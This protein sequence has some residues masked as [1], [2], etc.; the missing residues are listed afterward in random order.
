MF[1]KWFGT[2]AI[3]RNRTRI[4]FERTGEYVPGYATGLYTINPDGSDVRH[5]RPSGQSPRWSPDGHWI[6]FSEGTP[7]NGG[8]QSVFLMKPDGSN[9]RQL[10]YHKDVD[11]T[12]PFW[13]PDSK[14]LAYSLW[15]SNEK[16]YQLCVV[17]IS[18]RRWKHLLYVED[19]IYPVWSPTDKIMFST[20]SGGGDLRL[21]EIDPEGGQYRESPNFEPGDTEPVWTPDATKVVFGRDGSVALMDTA[22]GQTQVIR[23][24]GTAIQWAISPD[25]QS[26]AYAA[27]ETGTVAGFEIFVIELNKESKRK[28]VSNPIVDDHEVDSRCLSWSPYL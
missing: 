10:T 23:T 14:W 24:K 4:T 22:S 3:R 21:F 6:A 15:L 1:K 12:P 7:D 9:V 27:Q 25:G 8:L 2:A 5:I 16:R 11:A 28:L 19:A 17:E 13:S 26:I 20:P 18:T